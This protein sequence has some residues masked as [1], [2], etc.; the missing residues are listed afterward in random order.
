MAEVTTYLQ[1]ISV[2]QEEKSKKE[3]RSKAKRAKQSLRA[4]ILSTEEKLS[5][6]EEK[7]ELAQVAFPYSGTAEIEASEE[8]EA[9]KSG[10]EKL[11][12]LLKTK[13]SD[14]D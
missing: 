3:F 1:K 14:V 2:S 6:A 11:N 7:Y 5:E 4:D 9:Y 8:V 10:L 12:N 13:F